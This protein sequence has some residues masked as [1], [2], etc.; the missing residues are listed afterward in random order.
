MIYSIYYY[1]K[2][3]SYKRY[4]NVKS[5]FIDNIYAEINGNMN[6]YIDTYNVD[7]HS[8]LLLS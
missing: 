2:T 7:S 8:H 4:F 5:F 6:K 3:T 1:V